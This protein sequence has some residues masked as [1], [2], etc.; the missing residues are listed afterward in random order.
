M[1][2]IMK[3]HKHI[4]PIPI[5]HQ[6]IIQQ[7]HHRSVEGVMMS[8]EVS[9]N[10]S[11]FFWLVPKELGSP[12]PLHH[13]K[14]TFESEFWANN[15]EEL[16]KITD[17]CLAWDITPL[18]SFQHGQPQSVFFPERTVVLYLS[19]LEWKTGFWTDVLLP[20]WV[21]TRCTMSDNNDA[22]WPLVFFWCYKMCRTS[23]F[24]QHR[25]VCMVLRGYRARTV[26]RCD[27]YSWVSTTA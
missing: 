25:P 15:F 20:V 10:C 1:N 19:G 12:S 13:R 16:K 11:F 5:Y 27:V 24:V 9:L 7:W 22:F 2:Y 8:L 6:P 26:T 3:L 21:G 14:R 17:F 18:S 4:R 23:S